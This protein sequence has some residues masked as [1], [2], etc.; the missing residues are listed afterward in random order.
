MSQVIETK[1][2]VHMERTVSTYTRARID[3]LTKK[4]NAL[5]RIRKHAF[6]AFH[7]YH[8]P[9]KQRVIRNRVCTME[10]SKRSGAFHAIES[11]RF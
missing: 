2:M 4:Q 10:R 9:I 7:A 8:L 3:Q 1:A 5:A 11:Q 6:H